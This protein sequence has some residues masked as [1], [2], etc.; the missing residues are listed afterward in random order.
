MTEYTM[1]FCQKMKD[2]AEMLHDH[3]RGERCPEGVCEVSTLESLQEITNQ[4]DA[5]YEE[6]SRAYFPH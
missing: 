5:R 1:D 3:Y 6:A 2:A 4:W